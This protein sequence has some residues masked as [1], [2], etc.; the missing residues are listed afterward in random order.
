M[1]PKP[2]KRDADSGEVASESGLSCPASSIHKWFSA[3]KTALAAEAIAFACGEGTTFEGVDPLPAL[4]PLV[5]LVVC[6]LYDGKEAATGTDT[7]P[8]MLAWRE[9]LICRFESWI[10]SQLCSVGAVCIQYLF[11][12]LFR[13]KKT[14]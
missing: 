11:C 10:D 5:V 13:F 9:D 12:I 8:S 3:F 2:A 4:P 6:S 14:N 1:T 7:K